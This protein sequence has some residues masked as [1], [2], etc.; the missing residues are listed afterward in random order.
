MYGKKDFKKDLQRANKKEHYLADL[1][2]EKKEVENVDCSSDLFDGSFSDWD[3]K[4]YFKDKS[5]MTVEL[6]EDKRVM[7]TG[8]IAVEYE[9]I[10]KDG[11]VRPTCISISK[12]DLYCY[13]FNDNFYFIETKK[14]KELVKNKPIVKGG[15]GMRSRCYLLKKEDY[16]KNAVMV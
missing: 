7:E 9:R 6:K 11:T 14:L 2:K 15:D 16:L 1:L 10:L 8:N 5:E 12:S 4:I 13:N 3:L